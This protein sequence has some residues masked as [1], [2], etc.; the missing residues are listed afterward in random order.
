[1]QTP[2]QMPTP[3]SLDAD[4]HRCKPPT[5]WMQT[6]PGHVTS[7]AC[8]GQFWSVTVYFNGNAFQ[9]DCAATLRKIPVF[10]FK[11]GMNLNTSS[12]FNNQTVKKQTPL[13][14]RSGHV[15]LSLFNQYK[16]Q[17]MTTTRMHS[18]RMCTSHLLTVSDNIPGG[19]NP[20]PRV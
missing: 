5:P 8:W 4:P 1:M 18:S 13:C 7:D 16:K 2:P 15:F 6:P 19:S 11:I 14:K 10:Y 12:S 20:P 9:W 3:Y 17:Q